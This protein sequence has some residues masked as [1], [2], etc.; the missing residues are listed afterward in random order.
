MSLLPAY[1]IAV[2]TPVALIAFL[3]ANRFGR[4]VHDDEEVTS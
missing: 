1:G 2:I 4:E 3:I